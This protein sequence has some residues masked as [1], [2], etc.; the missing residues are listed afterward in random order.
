M[1]TL[2]FYLSVFIVLGAVGHQP[3]WIEMTICQK[4]HFIMDVVIYNK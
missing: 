3:R 4:N 1:Y 2:Q